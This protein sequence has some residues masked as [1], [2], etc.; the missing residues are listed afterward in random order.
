MRT[1]RCLNLERSFYPSSLARTCRLVSP[2]Y[3]SLG[4]V[5]QQMEG[6]RGMTLLRQMNSE[7]LVSQDSGSH[8]EG[9]LRPSHIR[10]CLE[11]AL[12]VTPGGSLDI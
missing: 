11:T 4:N 6:L 12:V 3:K 10:Q 7:I 9:G 2:T 8:P 1:N 5:R